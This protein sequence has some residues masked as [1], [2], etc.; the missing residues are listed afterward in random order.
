M[1]LP[2]AKLR[3]GFLATEA[4]AVSKETIRHSEWEHDLIH[5]STRPEGG[6]VL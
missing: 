1:S 4:K 3:T 6:A 2:E 5:L